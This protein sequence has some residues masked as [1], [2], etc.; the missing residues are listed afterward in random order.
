MTPEGQ[1]SVCPLN[2]LRYLITVIL[3]V[4]IDPDPEV[5]FSP[6]NHKLEAAIENLSTHTQK[7]IVAINFIKTIIH[8]T[9]NML[10]LKYHPEPCV[11][12]PY[13]H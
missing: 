13:I 3:R 2:F 7:S 10:D 9:F 6:C 11:I 4:I 8:Y 12:Q 5:E 1:N